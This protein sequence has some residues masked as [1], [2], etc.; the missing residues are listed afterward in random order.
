[1]RQLRIAIAKEMI[2]LLLEWLDL[3]ALAAIED[4]DRM[5]ARDR[6]IDRLRTEEPGAA[7]DQDALGLHLGLRGYGGRRGG[8]RPSAATARS[9]HGRGEGTAKQVTTRERTTRAG[10]RR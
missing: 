10:H 9:E 2:D 6:G 1:R 3:L 7:E 4:R 5:P 8:R